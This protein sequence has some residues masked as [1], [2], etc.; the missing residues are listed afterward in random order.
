MLIG[1]VPNP[2]TGK[3]I[4]RYT[5]TDKIPSNVCQS[6]L[7][8]VPVKFSGE[9]N[10][11]IRPYLQIWKELNTEKGCVMH[12]GRV[13]IPRSLKSR[14][15]YELHMNHPGIRPKAIARTYVWWTSID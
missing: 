12:E 1:T 6:L 3:E 9:N 11:Y 15:L 10:D 8:N 4:A 5:R 7:S 2:I 13:V 14:I